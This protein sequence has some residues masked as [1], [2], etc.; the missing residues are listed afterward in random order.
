MPQS[1]DIADLLDRVARERFLASVSGGAATWLVTLG[2]NNQTTI[3]VVAQ[4]WERPR[5]TVPLGTSLT[6]LFA[7]IEPIVYFRY[8][9]QVDPDLVFDCLRSGK[10]L[11][12]R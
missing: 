4:Q 11:P 12:A 10:E 7:D 3:G 9:L 6:T 8:L 1:A 5:L 2:Q